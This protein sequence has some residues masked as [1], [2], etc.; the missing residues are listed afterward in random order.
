M[1]KPVLRIAEKVAAIKGISV[2]ALI[3]DL[4]T[5]ALSQEII[6]PGL[7]QRIVRE[8]MLW[9]K[10][11]GHPDAPVPPAPPSMPPLGIDKAKAS[12]P[13]TKENVRRAA[14]KAKRH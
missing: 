11:H 1:P 13:S 3:A 6:E 4:V 2:N 8:V 9:M 10:E 7:T 5:D 12:K 14:S